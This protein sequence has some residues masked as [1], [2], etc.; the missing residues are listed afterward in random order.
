[1]LT[2]NWEVLDL[3]SFL[4]F[5]ILMLIPFL[6]FL[7]CWLENKVSSN[8][9]DHNNREEICHG[10][11]PFFE[12]DQENTISEGVNSS[13]CACSYCGKLSHIITRCLRCK[14]ASYCSKV[15][16]GMHWRYGHN[17]E[18]D[19]EIEAAE[20]SP[21][22][23][24]QYLL[25]EPAN[26]TSKYSFN[27]VEKTRYEGDVYYIEGGEEQNNDETARPRIGYDGC[28]VCGNP[29]SKKCSRCKAI[30]YCSKACQLLDWNSGHKFQCFVDKANSTQA[31]MVVIPTDSNEVEDNAPSTDPL[32]LEFYSEENTKALVLSSQVATNTQEEV[33]EQFRILKEELEK[34]KYDCHL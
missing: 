25:M 21:S 9:N 1:M 16:Q 14:N 31:A 12:Q 7:S 23:G 33:E 18:C 6:W 17:Y 29:C 4:K 8:S 19:D 5:I 10:I 24:T 30:K 20:G 11:N 32:C 34:I 13:Y 28:A 15:C 22:H 27:E 3:N 26:E 2:V